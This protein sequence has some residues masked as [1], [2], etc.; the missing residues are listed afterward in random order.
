MVCHDGGCDDL[1]FQ[2]LHLRRVL[3][4][5]RR[6]DI[7]ENSIAYKGR[8]Y[9]VIELAP[10]G[11]FD[12]MDK[13]S[14]EYALWDCLCDAIIATIKLNSDDK[15]IGEIVAHVDCGSREFA[16]LPEAVGCLAAESDW[17]SKAVSG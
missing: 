5:Y 4:K 3:M 13:S 16:S 2:S 9:W 17:Y 11:K 6:P 10:N 7:G 1:T 14:G 8:R 15:F 12:W